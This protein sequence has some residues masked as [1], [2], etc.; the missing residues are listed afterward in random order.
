VTTPFSRRS[1][2]KGGG[3]VAGSLLLTAKSGASSP[4]TSLPHF[5][6]SAYASWIK[7]ENRRPGSNEWLT[8]KEAAIG[9]LDGYPGVTSVNI[10]HSITFYVSTTYP[11]FRVKVFR[12]GYYNGLG[13]RLVETTS[14][15][16]GVVQEIPSPNEV[17]TVDCD[18][19][20]SFTLK[21]D[22]SYLPGQYLAMLVAP[23]GTTRF[24]PFL[25]RDDSSKSTYVYMSS[26]NTY[27]AY[28]PWGGLSLYRGANQTG[29]G[30]FTNAVRADVISFNRPYSRMMQNGAG[31]FFGN[32]LPL[33]FLLEQLGLDLT[34]WTNLDL[35]ER[36]E[37]LSNH[38]TLLSLGHDEYYSPEMREATTNAV[39]AG[40]NVAY[41]GANFIYR[42]IRY[43]PGVSGNNRLM[44][45]YRSTLDPVSVT[46]PSAATVNWQDYPSHVPSSTFTGS[47]WGGI[48]GAGSLVVDDTSTWLWHNSGLSD[49][50]VLDDALGGEF[51]RYAPRALNPPNVQILAHSRVHGGYADITY[52][53]N[54][55][56]GGIFSTGTGHWVY[57]LSNFG[58]LTSLQQGY[59]L[60][61][62]KPGVTQP[63]T[64]ATLN[65]LS[66]FSTG[67]A[68]ARQPSVDNTSTYY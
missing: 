27:Q 18:W 40:V 5:P 43:E 44:V 29:D 65:V 13:A 55:G 12:M 41:F 67:L 58:S 9:A 31:D 60:A 28:N 66:L 39:S 32:E 7:K 22:S 51:N 50:A 64:Q 54:D 23:D 68:S 1:V 14:P 47:L 19:S 53:A 52:V 25:V 33:L 49:G 30:D 59:L 17:G 26:I 16:K 20:P 21:M 35:H 34:Y 42:K 61:S 4:V 56:Q 8:H 57:D 63:L 38:Q 36:G 62:T 15:V 45:N 10:G 24:I 11:T 48:P 2:L 6:K 37:L 46:D 3:V